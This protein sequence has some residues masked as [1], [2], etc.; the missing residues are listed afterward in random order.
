MSKQTEFRLFP[1]V[2]EGYRPDEPFDATADSVQGSGTASVTLSVKGE[3]PDGTDTEDVTAQLSVYGPGEVTAVDTDQIVRMEPEPAT[4]EFPPNYFPLVEFDNPRLPWQFSPEQADDNGRNRPW[5]CLVVVPRERTTLDPP[6]TGPLPVLETETAELPDA[7]ESWAW[8]HA[9][10]IGDANATSEFTGRSTKTVAR[11][12]CPRNLDPQTEYRACVVPTFE[13]G[14][15]AGLG[16]DPY[17]DGRATIDFAWGA[18]ETVRLPVYHHWEFTSSKRG[19]FEYLARELEPQTFEGDVGFR[20]IDVSNPGPEQ[21]KPAAGA[22]TDV[23]TVGIGGALQAIGAEPDG[24]DDALASKL[25]ELLNKPTIVAEESDYGTVGPPLY[26]QY[27]AGVP[28]LE[29][30]DPWLD[31][32]NYYYPLWFNS[33]N[34]DPRHR[35]ASGY[36]TQVIKHHQEVLMQSAWEQF[37]E[38]QEANR[39]LN[40]AQLVERIQKRRHADLDS[41]STGTLLGLTEPIHGELLDEESGETVY[42]KRVDSD[43]PAELA[44]P[45]FRRIVRPQGPLARREGA[46]LATSEFTTRLET[47]RIPRETDGLGTTQDVVPDG[48]VSIEQPQDGQ[49]E[50]TTPAE[51]R[52]AEGRVAD[53][54][55]PP[56]ESDG[57]APAMFQSGELTGAKSA[58]SH[59]G[60]ER[61]TTLLDSVDTHAET[62]ERALTELDSA[63]SAGESERIRALLSESPTLEERCVSIRADTFGPLTRALSKLFAEDPD[64]LPPELQREDAT[65]RLQSLQ[66]AQRDL[67]A[68]VDRVLEQL[69]AEREAGATESEG[70]TDREGGSEMPGRGENRSLNRALDEAESALGRLQSTTDRIRSMLDP[71]RMQARSMD[72]IELEDGS[73][74][75]AMMATESDVSTGEKM[76]DFEGVPT[77][78]TVGEPTPAE[79]EVPDM[80]TLRETTLSGIDPSKRLHS[81]LETTLQIPNLAQRDD[82]VEEVMAAPTFTDFTYELLAELNQECFL[83]GAGDIPKNSMGVLQT[84]PEFIEAYM[85]GLNHEMARELRWRRYP[86]DRRG[87]Y[88][89]R[90]WDRRGNPDIDT[91]DPEQMADIEPM[92]T[93]D[94]NDLGENSPR[95]DDAQVVLLIKGELLRRYPNTDVFA[96]KAVEDDGDRVPALPG[97]HVTRDLAEGE[98]DHPEVDAV[99]LKYPVFR[100][101]LE[102]DITFFGFDLTP[103]EALYEPYH[104]D[105]TAKSPDDHPDE[106]WFFVLQE[107]PAE[108]RFG[109]DVGEQNAVGETPPGITTGDGSTVKASESEIRGGIEHG[110]NAVSWAHLIDDGSPDDV[111]HVSVADSVPGQEEWSV[112]E[113]TTYVAAGSDVESDH[114]YEEGDAARWGHNSAH[115][116]RFTWQLPVRVSIHADDMITEDTASSWREY[117]NYGLRYISQGEL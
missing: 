70:A 26:G 11:L 80:E 16:L 76:V 54:G 99:D 27:H 42:K 69:R 40:R 111:T 36:G 96:A 116:A 13:P 32:E 33:L 55:S 18:D 75:E 60:I 115:M 51:G 104:L 15:R 66:S 68:A 58:D 53:P 28:K 45:A 73:S 65:E 88:F 107:P 67:E 74:M 105:E 84:N 56:A 92:H 77:Q 85:A 109:L 12:V 47:G 103:D 10:L 95:D 93:W 41:L 48:D 63:V 114:S 101:K 30:E 44:S 78:P 98:I 38:I 24:Y 29:D 86:T 22:D 117:H 52:V 89:R 23:G 113:N 5:L 4:T 43:L 106:G 94:E 17:P 110:L 87:T 83:P 71:S 102:P 90:F 72:T 2:R 57:P 46:E 14:R 82:P 21:L 112:E 19:D 62:A 8:A 31:M 3:G 34:T 59:P 37:G 108:T 49:F 79:I 6:G 20:T 35:I 1:T 9:Q 91:D 50:G 39:Q 100:G 61:V 64:A 97:T 81:H 7:A 25:K